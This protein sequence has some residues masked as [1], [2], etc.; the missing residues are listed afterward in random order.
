MPAFFEPI[1]R[2]IT[3]DIDSFKAL[4]SETRVEL[5]KTFNGR[6]WNVSDLSKKF[7]LSKSTVHGHLL[8]LEKSG[9]ISKIEQDNKWV[10]YRLTDKGKTIIAGKPAGLTIMV[11]SIFS[12]LSGLLL[13]YIGMFYSGVAPYEDI[14]MLKT[15]VTSAMPLQEAA[16][17]MADAGQAAAS[18]AAIVQ[19]PM[20]PVQ[21]V[22]IMLIGLMLIIG[23][24]FLFLKRK[25]TGI[26]G[27]I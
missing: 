19:A 11:Y 2:Q 16:P 24:L 22:A 5:L 1:Q 14:G 25:G 26:A 9:L 27:N 6:N 7:E 8:K 12:L 17:L 10:Y 3:L 13:L 18:Q 15:A 20:L 4:S 21:S 23:S